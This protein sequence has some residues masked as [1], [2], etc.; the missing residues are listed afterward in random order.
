MSVWA[1]SWIP[2]FALRADRQE[3]QRTGRFVKPFSWKNCCSPAVQ[4]KA[5]PQ[6]R[7]ASTWSRYSIMDPPTNAPDGSAAAGPE[8][9]LFLGLTADTP[10]IRHRQPSKITSRAQDFA[11]NTVLFDSRMK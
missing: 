8:S 11:M 3:A 4:V 7:H 5:A 2:I 9:G 10:H 1:R 6:S